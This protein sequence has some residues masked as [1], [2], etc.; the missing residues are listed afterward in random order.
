MEWIEASATTVAVAVEAAMAE[1]GITDR[2]EAVVE[3]LQEPKPGFLGMGKQQAVVKVSRKATAKS[4]SRRRNRGN[5]GTGSRGT[6]EDTGKGAGRKSEG[7]GGGSRK[8]ASG[9]GRRSATN[10]G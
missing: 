6:R 8:P 4:G 5:R 9:T 10:A 7:D 2:A 1:L 3:V